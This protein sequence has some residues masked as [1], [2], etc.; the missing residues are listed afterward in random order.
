MDTITCGT[1]PA[2]GADT[3]NYHA[4][5]LQQA[6]DTA[7]AC[8][9][10]ADSARMAAETAASH[11]IENYNLAAAF[12]TAA[13]EAAKQARKEAKS[14]SE[15]A[16]YAMADDATDIRCW[17]WQCNKNPRD[18]QDVAVRMAQM[19]G[20]WAEVTRSADQAESSCRYAVEARKSIEDL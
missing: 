18:I 10:A 1:P 5:Q 19:V 3:T 4:Q 11:G 20:L 9:N 15:H 14:A 6:A 16:M 17:C 12:A 7:R 8:A 13:V 2:I